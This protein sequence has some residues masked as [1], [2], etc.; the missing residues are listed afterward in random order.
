MLKAYYVLSHSV[1]STLH[2]L[3]AF[4]L[5][6]SLVLGEVCIPLA[7]RWLYVPSLYSKG[8]IVLRDHTDHACGVVIYGVPT[9]EWGPHHFV[10]KLNSRCGEERSRRDHMKTHLHVGKTCEDYPW[11][12]PDR[13][14]GPCGAFFRGAPTRIRGE[15]FSFWNLGNK[16]HTPSKVCFLTFFKISHYFLFL[17]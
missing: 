9:K 12:Y 14:P 11:S 8:F 17:C 1:Q 4:S 6:V 3:L 10:P 5:G 16:Y 7:T 2:P 13:K 15:S